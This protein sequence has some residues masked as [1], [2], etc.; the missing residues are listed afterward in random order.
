MGPYLA[1]Q[2]MQSS[3]TLHYYLA[4]LRCYLAD[5]FLF[6]KFYFYL[7]CI[8][9]VHSLSRVRLF[10]TPWTSALQAFL[11][12]TNS[13]GLLK[14]MSIESVMTSNHLIL[15]Q[16]LLLPPS[17]FSRIRVFSNT[18]S[19]LGI[20]WPKNWNFSFSISPSNEYLDWFP[21]GLTGWISFQPKWL[22]SVFSNTMVQKHQFFSTQLSL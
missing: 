6:F 15:C 3:N 8:S 12:I 21:L 2:T 11:S 4:W 14:L 9:S 5:A 16:P 7:D 20:R 1:M 19:V 22:S 10:A 13:H 18:S 17:M